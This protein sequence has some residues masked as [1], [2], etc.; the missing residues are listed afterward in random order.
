MAKTVSIDVI[1]KSIPSDN[2]RNIPIINQPNPC[3]GYAATAK[4]VAQLIKLASYYVYA[5][6][7]TNVI[8]KVHGKK[9]KCKVVVV[10]VEEDEEWEKDEL[11]YGKYNL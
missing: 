6:G 3:K 1:D 11:I 2:T 8:A 7:T 4:E 5:A 9:Y 10:D